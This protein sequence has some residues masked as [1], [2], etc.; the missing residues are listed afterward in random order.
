MR[1]L[2]SGNGEYLMSGTYKYPSSTQEDFSETRTFLLD[3]NATAVFTVK[4]STVPKRVIAELR[5]RNC[6]SL[7]DSVDF[8]IT[9]RNARKEA[10]PNSGK[11]TVVYDA[12]GQVAIRSTNL[13]Q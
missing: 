4:A 3:Q 2:V 11:F 1:V 6:G 5:K 9:D 12:G 13:L 10:T 7:I 8:P